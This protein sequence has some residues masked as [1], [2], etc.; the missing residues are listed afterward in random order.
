MERIQQQRYSKTH[1]SNSYMACQATLQPNRLEPINVAQM[2]D[3]PS[4]KVKVNFYGPLPS[5]H[6][7]TSDNEPLFQS[8]LTPPIYKRP[9]EKKAK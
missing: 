1:F 5:G 8:K 9:N 7:V 3:A 2:P 4:D 6:N